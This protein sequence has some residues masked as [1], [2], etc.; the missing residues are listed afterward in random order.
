MRENQQT[1]TVSARVRYPSVCSSE[2]MHALPD[3]SDP[4]QAVIQNVPFFV[5]GLNFGDLVGLGPPDEMGIRPIEA[6]VTPSGHVRFLALTAPL[7]AADLFDHLHGMFPEYA[8]RIEGDGE[9]LLA[10]SVHPD[11]DPDDVAFEVTL[12][13]EEHGVLPGD[14]SIGISEM[15]GSE[16]GPLP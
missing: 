6:V 16:I 9:G 3:P 11:L 10:I 7:P 13:F 4:D 1:L 2:S 8:V 15:L 12:W 5:D 14:D